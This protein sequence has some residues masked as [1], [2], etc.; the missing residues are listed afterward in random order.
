MGDVDEAIDFIR[1][2]ALNL[3]ENQGFSRFTGTAYY[4]EWIE[5]RKDTSFRQNCGGKYRSYQNRA[6]WKNEC[7]GNKCPRN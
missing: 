4:G 5:I 3:L 6:V 7:N 2:Y 1:Y